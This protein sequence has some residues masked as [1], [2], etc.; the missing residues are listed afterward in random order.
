DDAHLDSSLKAL[1][2]TGPGRYPQLQKVIE[3]MSVD[4]ELELNLLFESK[5]VPFTTWSDPQKIVACDRFF[6]PG[7]WS[8]ISKH[9]GGNRVASLKLTTGARPS[10]IPTPNSGNAEAARLLEA[11]FDEQRAA[12]EAGRA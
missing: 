6:G 12:K 2:L 4:G 8:E 1:G 7:V 9:D 3:S 10:S 5:D 11:R